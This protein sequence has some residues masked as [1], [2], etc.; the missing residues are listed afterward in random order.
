MNI[1]VSGHHVAVT[2]SMRNYIEE[3]LV[4]IRRH[5][6]QVIDVNVIVSVEKLRQK[7]EVTVHMSGKDIHV[8]SE[9]TDLYAAFDSLVDKLDRRIL[10]HKESLR[11]HP[12]DSIKHRVQEEE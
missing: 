3:K 5:F 12:H 9:D 1:H 11:A 10:K 4:R 2:A 8:E 7:A 6:E